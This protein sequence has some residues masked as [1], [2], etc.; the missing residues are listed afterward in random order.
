MYSMANAKGVVVGKDGFL[1]ER[2]YINAH[3]GVD[4]IGSDVIEEKVKK[5]AHVQ[6]QLK[7]KG[8]HIV[9]VLAPGKGSFYPEY[10]PDYL[11]PKHPLETNLEHFTKEFEKQNINHLNFNS[12]FLSMKGNSAYPLY[13]KCGV[14]WSK[15]GEYLVADSLLKYFEKETNYTFPKLL[16]DTIIVD[17]KNRDGDYDIGEGMNL[18][19]ELD[20]Y[21]LA[22]PKYRFD[23]DSLIQSSKAMVVADSYYWGLFNKGMSRDCFNNGQFWYYNKQIFPESYE[24]PLSVSDVNIVQ[25]VE[26]ND[27]VIIICTDANLFKFAFGFVDVLYE[28]YSLVK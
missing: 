21:P 17:N 28:E 10:V 1:F 12:W 9:V 24:N 16:F 15:Y 26:K 3:F 25:E 19:Y 18:F 4:F 11:I 23:V 8:K 14:H 22:Y 2:N 7:K 13:P 27:I 5:L 6:E 20:T